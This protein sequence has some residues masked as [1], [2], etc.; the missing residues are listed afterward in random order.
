MASNAS[1]Q[2][3]KFGWCVNEWNCHAPKSDAESPKV[4]DREHLPTAMGGSGAAPKMK[5]SD[6]LI[7]TGSTILLGALFMHAW[8]TPTPINAGDEPYQ[9]GIN[10]ME[11]DQV[12]AQ[13]QVGNQTTLRV[14]MYDDNMDIIDTVSWVLAENGEETYEF[15]AE[16]GGFYTLEVDTNGVEGSINVLDVQRKL[17]LDLIPFPLGAIV[18]LYGLYQRQPSEEDD[19]GSDVM[20]AVLDPEPDQIG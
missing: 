8:V 16:E 18:L 5:M 11:G 13:I 15:M 17:M 9:T 20:D 2:A 19:E 7:L 14:V 3:E 4:L 1:P 12:S 6:A 10:M